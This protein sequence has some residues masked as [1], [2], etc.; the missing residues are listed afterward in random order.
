MTTIWKFVLGKVNFCPNIKFR[1]NPTL[2][3]NSKMMCFLW[4][5]LCQ[6]MIIVHR[7]TPVIVPTSNFLSP[8]W[9][10]LF[11]LF[12]FIAYL[13]V[14]RGWTVR[15]DGHFIGL[16]ILISPKISNFW[17]LRHG[18]NLLPPQVESMNTLRT[19]AFQ[20]VERKIQ[21]FFEKLWTVDLVK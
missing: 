2:S 12:S 10:F 9:E 14:C 8:Y 19:V 7:Q 17:S 21:C 13:F 11:Y 3:Q 15:I 5:P 16:N 6:V 18:I 20:C 1:H 4:G